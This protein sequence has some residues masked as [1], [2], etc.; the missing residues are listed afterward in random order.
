[1]VNPINYDKN[2]AKKKFKV[3]KEIE[4]SRD[5]KSPSFMPKSDVL[6]DD[7]FNNSFKMSKLPIYDDKKD[8][9]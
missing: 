3:I 1:M 2:K 4:N 9:L 7:E 8:G 5:H 6:E